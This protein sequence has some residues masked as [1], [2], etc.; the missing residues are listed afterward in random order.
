MPATSWILHI[1]ASIV[2]T[3]V[4]II[5][6]WECHRNQMSAKQRWKDEPIQLQKLKKYRHIQEQRKDESTQLF[7]IWI[8]VQTK[9]Q[10]QI[11]KQ[12]ACANTD[13]KMITHPRRIER[14]THP[15]FPP[16]A[17]TGEKDTDQDTKKIIQMEIQMKGWTHPAFP[18]GTV[19]ELWPHLKIME[20]VVL[21][22]PNTKTMNNT[23]TYITQIQRR[24]T[25]TMVERKAGT[26][27][28]G[29]QRQ[30]LSS[31]WSFTVAARKNITF[32]TG[33]VVI[34]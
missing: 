4:W 23:N 3:A 26:R 11:H 28:V 18:P 5:T 25:A 21:V 10:I 34:F 8:Q 17:N 29:I 7:Q 2:E 13:I 14:L 24:Y 32:Y 22:L 16:G 12:Y 33:L 20:W 30:A 6:W 27:K 19:G 9:I 31:S 1:R 15:A